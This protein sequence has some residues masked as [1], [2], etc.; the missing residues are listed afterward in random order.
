VMSGGETQRAKGKERCVGTSVRRYVSATVRQWAVRRGIQ[1]REQGGSMLNVQ[2][3][4]FNH[5]PPSPL[6]S[7]QGRGR[8]FDRAR[9]IRTSSAFGHFGH[10]R[11]PTAARGRGLLGWPESGRGF[12]LS[13]RERVRVRGKGMAAGLVALPS[14]RCALVQCNP[15]ARRASDQIPIF[16]IMNRPFVLLPFSPAPRSLES[17]NS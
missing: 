15:L 7:P 9:S 1:R 12:S 8:P 16:D 10:A 11:K 6:P 3:S 13:P 4:T 17:L 2:P 14:A 5:V